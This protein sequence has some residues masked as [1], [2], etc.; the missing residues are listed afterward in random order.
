MAELIF[1]EIKLKG[2]KGVLLDIDNTIYHYKSCHKHALNL[3]IE[4]MSK[5]LTLSK[6]TIKIEFLNSRKIVN[7]RLY[8]TAS[9][10]SRFLYIQL[11]LEKIL[12]F[13][14]FHN[15]LKMEKLYWD[16]FLE[17]ME[18]NVAAKKF[19]FECKKKTFLYVVLLT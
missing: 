16:I 7:K 13:S 15:T 8:D 4:E 2:F 19:I 3:L 17:K 1:P 18:L 9:S 11:T 14:D 10:H 5:M 6:E 12:G